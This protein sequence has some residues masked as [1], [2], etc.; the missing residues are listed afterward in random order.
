MAL[1]YNN[2]ECFIKPIFSF[3]HVYQLTNLIHCVYGIV[4]GQSLEYA[5]IV[6]NVPTKTNHNHTKKR[7]YRFIKNDKVDLDLLMAYWCKFIVILF[8]GLGKYVPLIVDITW[9]ECHKYLSNTFCLS[10]NTSS[11]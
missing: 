6:C 3:L 1:S 2:V 11:F 8:Y 4:H 7:I 5:Q 10:C 9:V